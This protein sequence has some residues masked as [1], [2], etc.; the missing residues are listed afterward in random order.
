MQHKLFKII[1]EKYTAGM[2]R[3]KTQR[4]KRIIHKLVNILHQ[5]VRYLNKY[6][7]QNQIQAGLQHGID[8]QMKLYMKNLLR[9]TIQYI[10]QSKMN[11]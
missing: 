10:I 9:S 5:Q 8:L 2:Q 11:Y 3:L 1:L 4:K 7:T 6:L